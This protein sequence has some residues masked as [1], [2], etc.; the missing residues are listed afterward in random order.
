[1]KKIILS[2]IVASFTMIL[3]SA[4]S[5]TG[6]TGGNEGEWLIPEDQLQ[7]GAVKDD[8]PALLNPDFIPIGTDDYLTDW[9]LVDVVKFG[10]TVRL[11]PI[12]ITSWHEIINDEIDGWKFAAS[13]CPVT[14]TALLWDRVLNGKETTF[15]V[16]GLLY[17]NN[18]ILYDRETDS[19]WSQML[20][21]CVNGINIGQEV[22]T[23]LI[24]EMSYEYAQQLFPD[25]R[26]ISSETGYDF[27]YHLITKTGE[28]NNK[29]PRRDRYYSM[30]WDDGVLALTPDD[31]SDS[32]EVVNIDFKDHQVVVLASNISR[33]VIGYDRRLN[34]GTV[35]EFEAPGR[36]N[37]TYF[38]DKT[39]NKWDFFG[40]AISGPRVGQRLNPLKGYVGFLFAVEDYSPDFTLWTKPEN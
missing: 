15:G 3:L 19:N 25:A 36:F 37:Q 9:D 2:I 20:S 29:L 10:N 18:L 33:F 27:P 4:C 7:F 30:I 28:S 23:T 17:M 12:K 35:L 8:I 11:Y 14:G 6:G 31:F 21:T 22:R 39:G 26:V 13:Y 16:S 24:L 32:L 5:E 1:M 34:D 38:V 40:E